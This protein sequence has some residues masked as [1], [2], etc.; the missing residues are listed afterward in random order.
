[1]QTLMRMKDNNFAVP[2]SLDTQE[3]KEIFLDAHF[4]YL[5]KPEEVAIIY[6]LFVLEGLFEQIG[7]AFRDTVIAQW[8]KHKNTYLRKIARFI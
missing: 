8:H 5:K 4:S 2:D 6:S 1:M 7:I 3:E